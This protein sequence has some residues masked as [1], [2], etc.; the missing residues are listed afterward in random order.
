MARLKEKAEACAALDPFLPRQARPI[1]VSNGGRQAIICLL[2][3]SP[4]PSKPPGDL[5]TLKFVRERV[6]DE[7]A[8]SSRNFPLPWE[9]P[10]ASFLGLFVTPEVARR[11]VK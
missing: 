10:L 5:V 1:S 8:E 9:Q 7:G 11:S 4:K 3:T 2:I 6:L